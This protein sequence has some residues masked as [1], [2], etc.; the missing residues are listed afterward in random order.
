MT[1]AS[2][3]NSAAPMPDLYRRIADHLVSM[4]SIDP[5]A[6]MPSGFTAAWS[7]D[8]PGM[9]RPLGEYPQ[10]I[11]D[12]TSVGSL[13]RCC[14]FDSRVFV[15]VLGGG[16]LTQWGRRTFA[17]TEQSLTVV[18]NGH[19]AVDARYQYDGRA[20]WTIFPLPLPTS[21]RA[22]A[23][24]AI[25]IARDGKLLLSQSIHRQTAA[26]SFRPRIRR[27]NARGTLLGAVP[28][29]SVDVPVEITVDNQVEWALTTAPAN[30]DAPRQFE[31]DFSRFCSDAMAMRIQV[32]NPATGV[33]AS[34]SPVCVFGAGTEHFLFA[35]PRRA[36]DRIVATLLSWKDGKRRP[37]SLARRIGSRL[38]IICH[39]DMDDGQ[40][41][42]FENAKNTF[43]ADIACLQDDVLIVADEKN[44]LA[45]LPPLQ[46]LFEL[47]P[48]A[49]LQT[50]DGVTPRQDK[51]AIEV[52]DEVK[53]YLRN[54]DSAAA[55]DCLLAALANMATADEIE[56]FLHALGSTGP[57]AK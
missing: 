46:Q 11:V 30:P 50:E 57:P 25:E 19:D 18:L 9:W 43:A 3:E 53:R 34:G 20:G 21:L 6:A 13:A 32:R 37:L 7:G 23:V 26:T 28:G 4:S 22:D 39:V 5:R 56:S 55:R 47:L 52:V 41:F 44:V 36:D 10:R 49:Q 29:V 1:A 48:P 54:G 27:V 38:D 40:A 42:R 33:D 8:D 24:T 17:Q 12:T 16:G 45:A 31:F 15:G 51:A 2:G 35:N 14:V